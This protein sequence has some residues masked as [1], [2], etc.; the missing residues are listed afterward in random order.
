MSS[1]VVGWMPM[2]TMGGV[3][4]I[5]AGLGNIIQITHEGSQSFGY[6]FN[7]TQIDTPSNTTL[8]LKKTPEGF[9]ASYLINSVKNKAKKLEKE[10]L[11]LQLDRLVRHLNSAKELDQMGLYTQL[12]SQ[13][14]VCIREQEALA[15]GFGTFIHRKMITEF[16]L[17]K[18]IKGPMGQSD[19]KFGE[20]S[21]FPRA[22]PKKP[23]S[24]IKHAKKCKLFDK[25][26]ILYLDYTKAAP[27][28]S[29]ADKV[30]EKDP[31]V[32]GSYS[33]A[34]DRLYFICDWV[35]EYCDLTF[36]RFLKTVKEE[37]PE[38]TPVEVPEVSEDYFTAIV[39]EAKIRHEAIKTLDWKSKPE[40]VEAAVAAAVRSRM[41]SLAEEAKKAEEANAER[42]AADL[43]G[44][45]AKEFKVPVPEIPSAPET[46]FTFKKTWWSKIIRW[47]SKP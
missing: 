33:Y 35:D 45:A 40:D 41:S 7:K 38:F 24:V 14:A 46:G 32:F 13:V 27:L 1:N 19:I 23:A 30:R 4:S 2:A 20:L 16:V 43:R 8:K 47:A 6:E 21:T 44:E 9:K 34:P 15:A 28:K 36:D 31:I 11:K 29:T 18:V 26:E 39:E 12:V 5:M 37:H 10:K 22:V 25:Y 3:S 42:L 17:K